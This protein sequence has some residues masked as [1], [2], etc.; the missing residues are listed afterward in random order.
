MESA[1]PELLEMFSKYVYGRVPQDVPK[2][3]WTVKTVDHEI[4]R[5]HARHRAGSDPD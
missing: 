1:C 4:G 3:S 5:L 2:V